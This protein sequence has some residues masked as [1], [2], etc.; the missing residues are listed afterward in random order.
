ME[1]F[2]LPRM[3]FWFICWYIYLD[4]CR[5]FIT[6]TVHGRFYGLDQ[7]KGNGRLGINCPG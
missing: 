6:R 3:G 2:V 1:D 4:I 5:T 7:K